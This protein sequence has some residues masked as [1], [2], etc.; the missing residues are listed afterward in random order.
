ME[1]R[2][3][4]ASR[5]TGFKRSGKQTPL[6]LMTTSHARLESV[7]R[8]PD[9]AHAVFALARSFRDEGMTQLELY[10]LF[11]SFRALHE[12][13]KD[14]RL[15]D[16]ILDTMDSILGWCSPSNRL[17]ETDLPADGV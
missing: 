15:Y 6:A 14:E 8:E 13:D 1:Q 4:R 12:N 5:S 10:R 3:A 16:A 7:L 2:R 17:Y 9:P 11:D